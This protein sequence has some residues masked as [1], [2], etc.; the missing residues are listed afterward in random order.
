M[1]I[2]DSNVLLDY[3]Q[4]I[5]E[6]KDLL[7]LTDVLKELDG[8]KRSSNNETAFQARRAAVMISRNMDYIDFLGELEK[9]NMPVDD[10]L[11]KVAGILDSTLV[12]NDVYLKVRA[13][14]AGVDVIG[15]GVKDDYE[16][17]TTIFLEADENGY[18]AVL[19]YILENKSFPSD[20][21]KKPLFENQYF[22][23]KDSN[24]PYQT[25]NGETDYTVLAIL[26][27][28]NKEL[29]MLSEKWDKK[30]IVNKW[31]N[32]I[33]PKN[34]EQQCLFHA[35]HNR[36]ISIIYAGGQFGTGY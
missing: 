3:P 15:Y 33:T 17:T 24:S 34:P 35:L 22:I 19:D 7:I 31:I 29:R 18:S 5:E 14:A 8:L 25:K 23:I 36:D 32:K 26:V 1:M 12:T 28:K 21:Y 13:R 16:G 30:T 27:Y 6:R 20:F 4:I 9:E 2:V 11:I 10:K